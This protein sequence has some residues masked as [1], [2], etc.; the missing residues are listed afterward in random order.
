MVYFLLTGAKTW[1]TKQRWFTGIADRRYRRYRLYELNTS[2]Y[3]EKLSGFWHMVT[4]FKYT[5]WPKNLATIKW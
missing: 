4:W 5:G 1:L 3:S 2:P